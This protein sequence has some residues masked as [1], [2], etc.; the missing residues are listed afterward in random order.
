MIGVRTHCRKF[1]GLCGSRVRRDGDGVGDTR[2]EEQ[3]AAHL[4]KGKLSTQGQHCKCKRNCH[5]CQYVAPD[6]WMQR[7]QMLAADTPCLVCKNARV[8]L[9]GECVSKQ[10]C[11]AIGGVVDGKGQFML[12]CV[13]TQNAPPNI[14][15]ASLRSG[16]GWMAPAIVGTPT[17][18]NK[19]IAIMCAGK[20]TVDGNY[21]CVCGDNCHTC[22][23]TQVRGQGMPA[24]AVMAA[25]A[26][27]SI[28]CTTCKNQ[29]YLL[30]GS[31]VDKNQC[32]K[33]GAVATGGGLFGRECTHT[34]TSAE[35][36]PKSSIQTDVSWQ[37]FV[38]GDAIQCICPVR[39]RVC[40]HFNLGSSTSTVTCIH[41]RTGYYL[42][43]GT[44]ISYFSCA[45]NMGVTKESSSTNVAI[46]WRKLEVVVV[47]ENMARNN[48]ASRVL[49][50]YLQT[51]GATVHAVGIGA[52]PAA[53][54][55]TLQALR[56]GDGELLALGKWC[57]ES[58]QH[59]CT[60]PAIW[61]STCM[62]RSH[63]DVRESFCSGLLC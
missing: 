52:E 34:Q 15:D 45:D 57:M 10:H 59:S 55:Q 37:T 16:P 41:C 11:A 31:C 36:A 3:A 19:P 39:C 2:T 46:C 28:T 63:P 61:R 48:P 56:S 9:D 54:G 18:K 51:L 33:A 58:G 30:H 23:Y 13:A 21:A 42:F 50:E 20:Q 22:W 29:Q 49:T 4:C 44:C 14:K 12:K 43:R 32:I 1:C 38:C 26:K 5:T 17:P 40:K 60:T 25:T 62:Q 8:L 24:S 53:M 7:A 47:V 35:A 6:G 27:R